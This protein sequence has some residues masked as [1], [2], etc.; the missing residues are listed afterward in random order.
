V[1]LLSSLPIFIGMQA[2]SIFSH[3]YF[4]HMLYL[5]FSK[6]PTTVLFMFRVSYFLGV[7]CLFLLGTGGSV[8]VSM[9]SGG[10]VSKF[11]FG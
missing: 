8:K 3:V 10:G 11:R 5:I 9:C 6:R 7:S 4:L 2:T 1:V